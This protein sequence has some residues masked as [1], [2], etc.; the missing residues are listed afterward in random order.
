MSDRFN[1]YIN[2]GKPDDKQ[3]IKILR[4]NLRIAKSNGYGNTFQTREQNTPYIIWEGDNYKITGMN[5]VKK[6]LFEKQ[7]IPQHNSKMR[8]RPQTYERPPPSIPEQYHEAPQKQQSYISPEMYGIMFDDGV[9]ESTIGR[10]LGIS[11]KPTDNPISE[12]V[13]GKVQRKV[14]YDELA[15]MDD[16][17]EWL[18]YMAG[19][20]GKNNDGPSSEKSSRRSSRR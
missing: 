5:K 10:M 11:T 17:E 8:P 6:I 9:E 14:K 12:S 20:M 13:S 1:L 3:L 19:C 4:T 16:Y 2:P 18:Y 7:P 15:G